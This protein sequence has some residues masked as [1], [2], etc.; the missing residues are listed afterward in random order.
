MEF[1]YAIVDNIDTT[2]EEQGNQF[3]AL[4]KIRWGD[5][6]NAHLEIRRWR[7]TPDGGEQCAKG[8]TF[9]TEEGP[10]ELIGA[11]IDLGFGE[12]KTVLK[13]LS[14]RDDFRKSLNSLLGSEDE[15]YD[16]EAGTLE[17]SYYDP[18]QLIGG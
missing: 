5:N 2:I 18:T 11:L 1:T 14:E 9:M 12:T 16:P 7:N 8:F 4:R 10:S 13:K 3:S 15:L 6:D 17:D